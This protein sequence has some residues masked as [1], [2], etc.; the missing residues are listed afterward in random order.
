MPAYPTPYTEV[1]PRKPLWHVLY[2]QVLAAIVI[3]VLL[4]YLVPSVAVEMKPL[5]D[6]FIKLIKMV[7]A[8]VVF[9][10]VVSG[11]SGMRDLGK[12]GRVG[13]K[14]LLYFEVV[15][16]VALALGLVVANI[17]HPGAGFNTDPAHLESKA[18]AQYAG[19]AHEQGIVPFVMNI[20]PDSVLGAFARGDILPVVLVA[21]VFGVVLSGMGEAGQP[22]RE[23]L[24]AASRWTFGV[25][26]MLMHLAPIGAFG[27][28]AFTIGRYGVAS[29]GPLAS[30]VA[31]LYLTSAVFVLVVL[32]LI[33]RFAG[34]NILRL[35]A[36]IKDDLLVVLGT[37]SSDPV[38]PT[39]MEKLEF[40]GC[41]KP[42][43]GLVV[44][45]GYVFNTDGSSIYM[46]M[47]ALFVAQATNTDLTLSQQ[48]AIL[49]VATLTSK[50]ASGVTGAAFIA[51]VA[52]LQVVPTIPVA[53]MALILGVDRFM[54]EMR[55]LVNVI[56]NAVATI[57]IARWEGELDTARMAAVLSGRIVPDLD[58]PLMPSSAADADPATQIA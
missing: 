8:L 14:S 55:A 12:V 42:V 29:L 19:A 43:V 53:G 1:K 17:F 33:A 36:Y 39:L 24:A 10:T 6:G 44:P 56:G 52:T 54:S 57:V 50:G 26:N 11:I 2:V 20:I 3:G 22:L 31:C 40:M 38:L 18:V 4:G 58:A 51:L 35:L 37:S 25:I 23:L 27:A 49:A 7:I 47:A 45:T 16:T 32:G 21:L 5:G 9:F 30:L 28:M 13:I 34:F 46:T 15:S 41:S 48:L